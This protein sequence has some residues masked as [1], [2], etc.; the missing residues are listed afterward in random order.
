[1]WILNTEIVVRQLRGQQT[2]RAAAR[3]VQR[4]LDIFE[5]RWHVVVILVADVCVRGDGTEANAIW[6]RK[7]KGL[8]AKVVQPC[9]QAAF[10]GAHL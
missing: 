10:P 8:G 3:V 1:M 6:E 9:L 2:S 7:R 4:G 5:W